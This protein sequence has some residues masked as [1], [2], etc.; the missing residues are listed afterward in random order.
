MHTATGLHVRPVAWVGQTF[1]FACHNKTHPHC[2]SP[3]CR[4]KLLKMFH[5]G[6]EEQ[7][8]TK[9]LASSKTGSTQT[10][11]LLKH[12]PSPI[13][14]ISVILLMDANNNVFA[15]FNTIAFL[16]FVWFPSINTKLPLSLERN[17]FFRD[18]LS[19][20]PTQSGP[21]RETTWQYGA[22]K[23]LKR[24]KK[25]PSNSAIKKYQST[26]QGEFEE[27]WIKGRKQ[28]QPS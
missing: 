6:S 15:R 10:E 28:G 19:I 13:W 25:Y 1:L 17:I 5:N 11:F 16:L 14:T 4:H 2:L 26:W 7:G 9:L 8:S 20:F 23:G 18:M 3:A 12:T 27:I 22:L 24:T 21:L